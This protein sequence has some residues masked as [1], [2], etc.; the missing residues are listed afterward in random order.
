MLHVPRQPRNRLAPPALCPPALRSRV[1]TGTAGCT[2]KLHTPTEPL[3][4]L[5]TLDNA[6]LLPKATYAWACA[7]LPLSAATTSTTKQA[8]KGRGLRGSA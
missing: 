5:A 2:S 4:L 7:G 8:R 3:R 1:C 6:A